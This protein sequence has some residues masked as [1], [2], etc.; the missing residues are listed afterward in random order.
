MQKVYL[1][2]NYTLVELLQIILRR[3]SIVEYIEL[4]KEELE[5]EGD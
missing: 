2:G 1:E 5:A 3:I 4:L